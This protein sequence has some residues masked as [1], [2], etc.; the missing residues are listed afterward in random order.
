MINQRDFGLDPKS[1]RARAQRIGIAVASAWKASASEAGLRSTLREYRRAVVIREVSENAVVVTLEGIL[2]N[3]LERGMAPHDMRTYLLKTVRPGASPIRRVKQGKRKGEPY[4]YIM[5]GRST[6]ETR[7]M[8]GSGALTTAKGGSFQATMSSASGR[9]L[10]GSRIPPGMS[11]HY[12]NKSGVRS[13]SDATS[14]M[15]RLMGVATA[16]GTYRSSSY[17]TWRT[18]ST[19]RASAWQHPGFT[20]LNLAQKLIPHIPD[21]ISEAGL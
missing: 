14:G 12:M 19:K 18:V 5:F 16:E 9:L 15:V 21:V 3:L 11:R 4:R 1:R 10:Y 7:A 8:G 13:V 20:A 6:K 2:P 17:A